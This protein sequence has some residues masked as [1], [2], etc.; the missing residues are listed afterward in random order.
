[1]I[2]STI[3][4]F[5][6][7]LLPQSTVVDSPVSWS[8]DMKKVSE[9]EYELYFKADIKKDWVVYAIDTPDGGPIATS[10]YFDETKGIELDGDIFT[11]SKVIEVEDDLF[12][13][14]VRK[15]KDE[16]VFVQ[17]IKTSGNLPIEFTGE[18]EFMTCDGQRCLPPTPV[19]F[20]FSL[21]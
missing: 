20:S 8:F 14:T 12:A 15:H 17:K 7:F 11:E 6:S 16:A 19:P 18:L 21:N 10:F 9:T 3:A 5:L 13:M 4:L 1:M 2:F